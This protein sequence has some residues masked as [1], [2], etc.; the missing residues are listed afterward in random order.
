ML[1]DLIA[2]AEKQKYRLAA[3]SALSIIA[4]SLSL[5]PFL[6]VYWLLLGL[7]HPS[8]HPE[9]LWRPVILLPIIYLL[10]YIL[11]IYAYD[12]SH[13]AAYEILYEI[14]LELGEKMTRLPLGYFNEKN[15][16]EMETIMNEN[17]ECLEL[18]LAHHLPELVSV[19]FTPLFLAALLILLDWRMAIASIFPV[20]M[21]LLIMLLR[22]NKW[23]EMVEK[24]MT[25]QSK[26]NSAIV[27]YT[28]GIA[29]IKAFN[30]TAESFQKYSRNV[31]NLRDLLV[32]WYEETALEFSLYQALVTSTLV[33][34]IPVG[35]WLYSRGDMGI[36]KFLL[37]LLVGPAF[38][39]LFTKLY[40]F[41]RYWME[42]TECVNRVNTLRN[43]PLINEGSDAIVMSPPCYDVTFDDVSFSYEPGGEQVLKRVSLNIPQGTICALV[44]PSGSGKT[45]IARLISRF[46]DV[47]KGDVLI[48]GLNVK[49]LS[50]EDLFSCIS[51]VFQEVFL[52]HGTILEN[53]KLGREDATQ[54]E[55][56]EAAR[57]AQ[58]HEFIERLP[59]GYHTTVD[60]R[61]A[62]LSSGER[63]RISIARALLKDAPIVIL[64]EATAYV[65]PENEALIQKAINNLVRNKTVL[66][67][68]HRLSTVIHVDQILVMKDGEIVERGYHEELLRAGGL[69]S[70][71][72]EAHTSALGWGIRR[73]CECSKNFSS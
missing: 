33:T 3:S 72:W 45:T 47:Q 73:G 19:I 13:R 36:E 31:A 53:I 21:A 50:G 2:L 52:F 28:Q 5:L 66:V 35:I 27:E 60:D 69:Y 58:C 56:I 70:R 16:G 1:G 64:D 29:T 67:I 57:L 17:V 61:G 51:L 20:L 15:T 18:F 12:L 44:G 59:D 8:H 54:E 62:N 7:F 68:A 11:L 71:M 39:G 43:A 37:F 48:G 4:S 30:R 14:R 10:S 42:E 46:W 65:D 40:P 38:G 49:F 34:I 55:I 9:D 23:P 63:Q 26:V 6:L 24:F 25:A 41:L 22:W 32:R